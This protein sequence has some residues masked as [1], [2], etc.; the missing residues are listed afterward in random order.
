MVTIN[1]SLVEPPFNNTSGTLPNGNPYTSWDS[2]V[3]YNMT[4]LD[5][6]LGSTTAINVAGVTTP[7]TFTLAQYQSLMIDFTG[8]L[9][10][11][12]L[13]NVP[14]GVGGFWIISNSCTANFNVSIGYNVGTVKIPKG[15]QYLVF[16]D[17][18]TSPYINLLQISGIATYAGNPNGNVG[19]NANSP[20]S[21]LLDTTTNLIWVC[22]TSGPASTAVWAISAPA[23]SYVPTGT[24][25][26]YY[27]TA[28]PAG[29]LFADFQA[30]SRTTYAALYAAIGT[31]CGPGDG[32]TTFNV[33]D[34]R[35]TIAVGAD[36]MGGAAANK[37][38]VSVNI[39][40]VS[41]STAATVAS[42]TGLCKGM[43][44]IA[45]GIT[46]GTTISSIV[47]TAV[48]LSLAAT[49][50]ATV[51]GRFSMLT[52]AEAI[53]ATG[54]E[55]AHQLNTAELA[56]HLH[57]AS[58]NQGFTTNSGGTALL[59]INGSAGGGNTGTTGS[60]VVHNNIQP[61]IVCNFII[62]T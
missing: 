37:L 57:V 16:V 44:I 61:S 51:A 19:G 4:A 53:G 9:S 17:T 26:E 25:L 55:A 49:A 34:K 35:G 46:A 12:V 27:G 52:D 36:N 14:A 32:S 10:N 20:A 18:T 22:T 30:V 11:D 62:K 6:A 40:T 58:N 42:A 56:S 60:D 13:Y 38:Q 43:Y 2:P 48:T 31:S 5:N 41:S 50:S 21:I 33:P 3:N 59:G 24:V 29:Y 8:A 47:G 54:G 28:A 7:Q 15:G 45:A 1:K 23:G 39:T